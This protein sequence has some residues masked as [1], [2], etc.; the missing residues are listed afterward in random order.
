M[1]YRKLKLR[2]CAVCGQSPIYGQKYCS[3]CAP[4]AYRRNSKQVRKAKLKAVEYKEVIHF[5]HVYSKADG[6]CAHCSE[7]LL[8]SDRGT[9]KGTAPEVDHIIPI[10]LGGHHAMYNVQLLCR[11]CNMEKGG[12]IS[13]KDSGA[14][15]RV[16]GLALGREEIEQRL[17]EAP[18]APTSTNT[19]GYRGVC[20]DKDHGM[21]VARVTVAKGKRRHVGRYTTAEEAGRAAKEARDALL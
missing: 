17:M 8:I 12:T 19:T 21:Y 18:H 11:R 6:I 2:S 9:T 3:H 5:E 15:Q 20:Y 16:L 7:R 4:I 1:N 13:S 10:S 14:V